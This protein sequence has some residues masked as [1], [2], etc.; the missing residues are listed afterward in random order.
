MSW[1]VELQRKS[2]TISEGLDK[3]I[4]YHYFKFF[5]NIQFGIS[6]SYHHILGTGN[7]S[8]NRFEDL[9]CAELVNYIT[10][11]IKKMYWHHLQQLR[12][13]LQ[14]LIFY[15]QHSLL[16]IVGEE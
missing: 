11:P 1:D 5:E 13:P 3:Y 4:A 8:Y 9:C 16:P 15:K 10:E 12:R 14:G 2:R 7:E 6:I